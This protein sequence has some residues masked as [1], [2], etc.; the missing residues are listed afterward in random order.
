MTTRASKRAREGEDVP[1]ASFAAR[2]VCDSSPLYADPDSGDDGGT[3][4]PRRLHSV[5]ALRRACN[6]PQCR[7]E[8]LGSAG[9]EEGYLLIIPVFFGT[10]SASPWT[11][12][13]GLRTALARAVA[14]ARHSVGSVDFI[15][16]LNSTL[17]VSL[18]RTA[19]DCDSSVTTGCKRH[20]LSVAPQAP[21]CIAGVCIASV[22][23][24]VFRAHRPTAT[25][26]ATSPAANG[27][28]QRSPTPTSGAWQASVI[29]DTWCVGTSFCGVQFFWVADR[30]RRRGLARAMVDAARGSICYGFVVP[31]EHVAFSEPT[32]AG[33]SFAE[34]YAG[35]GDFLVY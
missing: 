14:H 6:S 11:I 32:V 25:R 29:G 9:N 26:S 17:V 16:P 1:A 2:P 18:C 19:V 3:P 28:A 33:T 23:E 31:P 15:D 13:Q 8:P 4:L 5:D 22:Q 20:R 35:R 27:A 12:D 7:V 21:L 30:F 34:Q 10:A 24:R